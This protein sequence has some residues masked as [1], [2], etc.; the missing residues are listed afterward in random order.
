MKIFIEANIP[1][2][3]EQNHLIGAR[4]KW[5]KNEKKKIYE[6][7]LPKKFIEPI[8]NSLNVVHISHLLDSVAIPLFDT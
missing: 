6:K 3:F 5:K 7:C 2:H 4:L 8:G 1:L